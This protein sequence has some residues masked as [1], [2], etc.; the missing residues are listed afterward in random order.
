MLKHRLLAGLASATIVILASGVTAA[1]GGMTPKQLAE[2]RSMT[3]I[4]V[5][6]DGTRV[7]AVRSVPRAL[8]DEANGAPW[9]ELLVIDLADGAVDPFITGETNVSAVAWVPDGSGISFIAKR[10]GDDHKALYV[11]P[12]NG[13]EARRA[14]APDSDILGYS[15][16]P[17]ATRVAF[18]ATPPMSEDAKKLEEEGFNQKIYE[19]DWRPRAVWTVTVA[20]ADTEP[21]RLQLE[22]SAFQVRWSPTGDLL[23]VALAPT[24][25]VD[26]EYMRQKVHLVSSTTGEVKAIVNH[27][28]KL[29]TVA[30][31]PDGRW[32]S[33]VA[34]VDIHDPAESSLLVVPSAGGTPRNLTAGFAGHVNRVAWS[35]PTS[36]LFLG[37]VGTGTDLFTVSADGEGQPQPVGLSGDTVFTA[38]SVADDNGRAALIGGRATL[39]GEAPNHPGEA[40]ALDLGSTAPRR[41]TDSNPWL[42]EISLGRQEVVTY[43]ARDGLEID[44]VLVYPVDYQE[45]DRYPLVLVVHGGPEAHYRNGWMS[46]YSRPAQVFAARGFAVFYPNYRGSTGRGVQFS[47]T[48]QGDPAGKE[49]DDLVDGVDHLVDIGLVDRDR[50]GVTG[51]SYG[52]YATAWCAT[53]FS[54]RFAAGVMF[55]GL[56]NKHSKIGTTDIPDEEFYVHAL[57]RVYDDVPFFLERSPISHVKGART[58]L[59]I[60]HGEDDPRVSVTQSKELYRALK[61]T[62]DTPVRLVLFP[63]EGHGNRKAAARYD[64]M[65]RL[66]RWMEHYLVGEGGDPPPYPVDYRSSTDGW[67]QSKDGV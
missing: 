26:D 43:T 60:M 15:W 35:S 4:E 6:P 58:P 29:G 62:G 3:S 18:I 8:F 56:S 11:I 2:L 20:S 59:L 22:G 54:E 63:G 66:L 42:A 10:D 64:Y 38:L 30:W 25:L 12:A 45:G 57:K 52:G 19:E 31:S 53:R 27:E 48:S 17:D 7:A 24:P 16:S 21:T 67:D 50:V 32:I 51:G 61:I 40:F 33:M 39:I 65:L 9:A 41:L 1:A 23:A 55:V 28:G 14:V 13:G 5:S 49:F 47:R 44:G 46:R 36:L 34:G 37:D